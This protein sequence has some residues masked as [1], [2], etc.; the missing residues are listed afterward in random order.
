MSES[1]FDAPSG[2]TYSVQSQEAG[3]TRLNGQAYKVEILGQKGSAWQVNIE[4][5][6]FWAQVQKKEGQIYVATPWGRYTFQARPA[7]RQPAKATK[8]LGDL[9]APMDALVVAVM[10]EVG[11]VV[12]A[13]APLA[14]LEAMKMELRVKAPRAGRISQRACE[15]GQRVLRGQAL[16][17]LETDEA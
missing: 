13:G 12:E 1:Y 5:R 17:V 16:F 11:Q 7:P 15:V 9:T 6:V 10:G 3:Q 2:Q 14:I 4:G 8:P